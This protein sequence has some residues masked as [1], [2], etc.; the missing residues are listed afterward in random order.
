MIMLFL[1]DRMLR[2]K[3]FL[4]S[5][6]QGPEGGGWGAY[7]YMFKE[8]LHVINNIKFLFLISQVNFAK[9]ISE[10]DGWTWIYRVKVTLSDDV[11][12]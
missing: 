12:S 1:W 6:D 9:Y 2:D 5:G 10:R 4:E 3:L 11:E 8:I 7:K